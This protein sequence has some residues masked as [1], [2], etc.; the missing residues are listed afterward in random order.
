M[1]LNVHLEKYLEYSRIFLE[2][3]IQTYTEYIFVHMVLD[4]ACYHVGSREP[5]VGFFFTQFVLKQI[6]RAS[7]VMR[8]F[9][10]NHSV[11]GDASQYVAQSVWDLQFSLCSRN[12]S[13]NTL[14]TQSRFL[15]GLKLSLYWWIHLV[16]HILF[17]LG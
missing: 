14:N 16:W 1:I 13:L 2:S 4:R 8:S 12:N 3:S 11:V 6:C 9:Q 15:N 7:V 17:S 5:V 10:D